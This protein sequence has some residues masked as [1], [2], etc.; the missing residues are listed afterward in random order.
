MNAKKTAKSPPGRAGPAIRAADL[1]AAGNLSTR[2]N[3]QLLSDDQRAHLSAVAAIV[4]FKKGQ[5]IYRAD[6]PVDAIYNIISGVI[7]SYSTGPRGGQ[8]INAFL[9][10]ND[11]LG[12]SEE[13]RYTNSAEAITTATAYR[14]PVAK[15]QSHLQSDAKLEFH[16]IC[17]L[18]QELRQAQRH[19]FLISSRDAIAKVAMFLLLTEQLQASRGEPTNEI[20]LPM[21]RT[22][23]GEYVGMSLGAVSRAFRKLAADG[24]IEVRDRRHIR[25]KDR[26]AFNDLAGLSSGTLR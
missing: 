21:D 2:K 15:L 16:I 10:A 14:L 26:S 4:R 24:V 5:V 7:K 17:K 1:W 22:E 8:R 23:I 18:C 19:A 20:H 11:L 13:G 12:L 6:D 25:I 9:F 3:D